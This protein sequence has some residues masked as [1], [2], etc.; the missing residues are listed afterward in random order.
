MME[1]QVC[2]VLNEREP[3]KARAADNLENL[4]TGEGIT[5]SRIE[6]TKNLEKV[7]INRAPTILIMDFLLGDFSTGLDI[8]A[9]FAEFAPERRPQVIF[10]TDEPSIQV[11][12]EALKLGALD[13]VEMD[14]AD[15]VQKVAQ[16]AAN[17]YYERVNAAPTQARLQSTETLD[18]LVYQT[19]EGIQV[20]NECRSA[21]L[22]DQPVTVILAKRGMGRTALARAITSARKK[23]CY[24]SEID[25]DLCEE[26][27]TDLIYPADNPRIDPLLGLDKSLMIDHCESDNGELI[28]VL[29]QALSFLWPN[30]S[31]TQNNYL[32]LG[33]D[34][35]DQA[36]A[37]T[38]L[39]NASL[40]TIPDID[41]RK[42]D[43]QAIT[44]KAVRETAELGK[45]S[46]PDFG[47]EAFVHLSEKNWPGGLRQ[48]VAVVA[49]AARIISFPKKEP[50]EIVEVIDS[51]YDRWMTTQEM[52]SPQLAPDEFTAAIALE[53]AGGNKRIAAA[54]LGC[55]IQT[56]DRVVSE[57]T[58]MQGEA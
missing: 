23:P 47:T 4:L 18:E 30:G 26:K 43:I 49:D 19:K 33:T 27:L 35:T 17:K 32:L 8:M 36:R 13:Y 42:A 12:V 1:N 39:L 21:A 38:K 46:V 58:L 6:I 52:L 50:A 3:N 53:A 2:I 28:H 20:I 54:R 16:L 34:D 15:A 31:V 44:Q 29:E 5:S 25:L 10:L 41:T 48:L 14:S 22:S 57:L 7:L 56:L 45:L 9:K 51:C 11:A 24:F 55:T 37:L 40:I